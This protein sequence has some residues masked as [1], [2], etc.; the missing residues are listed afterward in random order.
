[1]VQRK[2][3]I[4]KL[5]K[6]VGGKNISFKKFDLVKVSRDSSFYKA[7]L[8]DCVIWP[9]TT[10]QVQKIMLFANKN[11]IP[12]TVRGGGTGLEGNAIPVQKGIVLEMKKMNKILEVYKDDY[13]VRVQPGITGEE[14]N[15]YLKKFNLFFP[16]FPGIADKATVGGMTATNA[17][18]TYTT[19]YNTVGDRVLGLK[20][21]VGNGDVIE[22]GGRSFKSVAG[23]DL[24]RL[25]MGS[26][27]TLGVITEIIFR[28]SPLISERR[29]FIISGQ[30]DGEL[31]NLAKEIYASFIK[32][33]AIE[34]LDQSY[35]K[36]LNRV[37]VNKLKETP[38]LIIELHGENAELKARVKMLMDKISPKNNLSIKEING[39]KNQEK[40][41]ILR[42]SVRQNLGQILPNINIIPGDV[43]VPLSKIAKLFQMIYLLANK[44]KVETSVF[45]HMGDGNFH[46]WAMYEKDN[47]KSFL[48]AKNFNYKVVEIAIKM[49]G[50]CT[51]EHGVGIGKRKQLSEEHPF[52]LKYYKAIKKIFDPNGILN[53]GKIFLNSNLMHYNKG[54]LC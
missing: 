52:N 34:Y 54:N 32:P 3:S 27:G 51:C 18:G 7:V 16:A 53:P 19:L 45:G 31:I 46:V 6:I 8:P 9:E 25:F 47:N 42:R 13:E 39:I 12:V 36:L 5:A 44:H 17:G 48:K 38:I 28:L 22:V 29:T 24:K 20:V 49:G 10:E 41:W 30:K 4:N 35:V 15:N 40:L 50:T 21:V 11:K 2:F 43:G 37:D 23:Y 1:M 26:D 14:L 33:A